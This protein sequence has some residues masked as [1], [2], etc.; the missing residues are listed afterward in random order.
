METANEYAA[1]ARMLL[2]MAD[3][4]TTAIAQQTVV[5]A[6]QVNATLALAAVTRETS[7]P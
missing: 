5:A 1:R 4:Q 6:A 2:D 3:H 7:R